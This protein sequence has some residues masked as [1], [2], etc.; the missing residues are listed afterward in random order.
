MDVK[1]GHQS[2]AENRNHLLTERDALTFSIILTGSLDINS[3]P[4][5]PWRQL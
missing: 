2:R 3:L 1:S 4:R 5:F